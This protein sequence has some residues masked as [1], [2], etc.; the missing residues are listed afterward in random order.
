MRSIGSIRSRLNKLGFDPSSNLNSNE[1]SKNKVVQKDLASKFVKIV[2]FRL[3]LGG[4][5]R[6]PKPLSVL[7]ALLRSILKE[8]KLK[9]R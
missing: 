2:V 4:Y 8:L 5:L 3:T 1:L 7:F 6:Y 9:N